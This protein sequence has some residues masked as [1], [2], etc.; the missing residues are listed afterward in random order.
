MKP[1][2]LVG[3]SRCGKCGAYLDPVYMGKCPMCDQY[4]LRRASAATMPLER[5]WDS[6]YEDLEDLRRPDRR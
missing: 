4:A 1:R 5:R 6:K 2:E 3:M